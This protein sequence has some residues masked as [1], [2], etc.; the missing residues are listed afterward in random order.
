MQLIIN[1]PCHTITHLY[2]GFQLCED[3]KHDGRKGTM[4]TYFMLMHLL[5]ISVDIIDADLVRQISGVA[6]CGLELTALLSLNELPN[7]CILNLT[8]SLTFQT[9]MRYYLFLNALFVQVTLSSF[10]FIAIAAPMA[11]CD[12]FGGTG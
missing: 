4:M 3:E 5:Y 11:N 10:I 1:P 8:A 7:L 12:W 9:C 6:W 2:F